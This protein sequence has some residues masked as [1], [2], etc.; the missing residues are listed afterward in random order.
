MNKLRTG[1]E[2]IVISGK[3][4]GKTGTI[5]KFLAN[6]KCEVA[7]IKIVK[8]HQKPNPQA[9]IQW[10]ILEIESPIHVSN[11]AIYNKKT[12]KADKVKIEVN[13]KLKKRIFKSDGKE[14]KWV[15]Q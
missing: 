3:D 12:K 9:N 11:I 6:N 1:D 5:T 13:E 2:V 4:R 10:G 14:I 15:I 7:G 8:K